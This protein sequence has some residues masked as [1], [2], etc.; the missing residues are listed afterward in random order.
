VSDQESLE[1][2]YRRFL[3][4]FPSEF[5][6]KSGEELVAVLMESTV[7]GEHRVGLATSSD[8]IKSGLWMRL[9]PRLPNAAP[10]VRAAVILMYVGGLLTALSLILVVA[11]VGLFTDADRLRVFGE[12]QPLW[13]SIIV[14]A[15]VGLGLSVSWL[16]LARALSRGRRGA[17]T[18]CTVLVVPATFHLFGLTGQAS[19]AFSLVTWLIGLSAV[20]LLWR[21]SSRAFFDR[22][23][24]NSLSR[25]SDLSRQTP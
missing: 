14:G 22:D 6:D 13:T 2:R 25:R 10:S 24:A 1:R 19:V 20:W 12:R 17:R 23:S 3:K 11:T 5:R 21:P 9:R 18:L 15:V 4:W 16:L 8:L 7:P